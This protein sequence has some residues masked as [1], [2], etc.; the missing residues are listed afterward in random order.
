MIQSASTASPSVGRAG[1]LSP[2]SS[3]FRRSP[4][5]MAKSGW[6]RISHWTRTS[7][8]SSSRCAKVVSSPPPTRSPKPMLPFT[9]FSEGKIQAIS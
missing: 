3:S 5:G 4:R 2:R 6:S 8:L 7:T 9:S 1:V